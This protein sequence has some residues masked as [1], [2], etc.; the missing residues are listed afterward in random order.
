M[1]RGQVQLVRVLVIVARVF[2]RSHIMHSIRY[3]CFETSL[4]CCKGYDGVLRLVVINCV[5]THIT[6]MI[7][8]LDAFKIYLFE[9]F[10]SRR[11]FSL[12][13]LA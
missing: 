2:T 3:F 11:F 1:D 12:R 4:Y 5:L 13:S 8:T 6:D 10:F 7:G 9:V